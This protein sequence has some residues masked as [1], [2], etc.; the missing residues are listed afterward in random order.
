MILVRKS[1]AIS[2]KVITP[3]SSHMGKRVQANLTPLRV[4]RRKEYY[5]YVWKIYSRIRWLRI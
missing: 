3:Q 1:L 5:S 4:T 2:I